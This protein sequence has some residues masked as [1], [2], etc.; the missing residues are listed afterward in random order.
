MKTFFRV[1]INLIYNL[2]PKG[3]A[4][5]CLVRSETPEEARIKTENHFQQIIIHPKKTQYVFSKEENNYIR[6]ITDAEPDDY[7]LI[8]ADIIYIKDSPICC[9]WGDND[10]NLY[11]ARIFADFGR[12][13]TKQYVAIGANDFDEAY[14]VIKKAVA[15]K[16][17][18]ASE[19]LSKKFLSTHADYAEEDLLYYIDYLK[20]SNLS[21]II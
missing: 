15:N 11:I 17:H 20:R 3:T 6:V 18:I 12:I 10:S 9:F 2:S 4:I 5:E 8:K 7:R 1:K 21:V 13:K 19:L 16:N 14:N